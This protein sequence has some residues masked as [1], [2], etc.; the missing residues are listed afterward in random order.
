VTELNSL[1]LDSDGN[2]V[3]FMH[4]LGD[5]GSGWADIAKMFGPQL[6]HVRFILPTAPSRRVTLNMGMMMP[7]WFVCLSSPN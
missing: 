5:T 4:G 3:I 2:Q 6:P 1:L 7:A